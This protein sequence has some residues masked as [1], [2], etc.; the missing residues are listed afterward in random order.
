MELETLRTYLMNKPG[1]TEERP[2]GPQALVYKIVGKMFALVAWELDP[3]DI[4]LKC[5][6]DEALFLRD[7][8]T[9]VRPGYH[10]NK[11]HWNTISLDG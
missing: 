9:A 7:M 6:P 11:R 5:D 8:Y 10:M 2:F 4:S 3:L 1:T